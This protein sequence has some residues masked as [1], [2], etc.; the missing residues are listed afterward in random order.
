MTARILLS[1]LVLAASLAACAGTPRSSPTYGQELDQLTD[2]CAERGGIL[3]P[4][5]GAQTG[6]PQ[7]D[8]A[9]EIRGATRLTPRN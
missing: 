4:I 8:Y 1:S 5:S 2:D 3:S 7:T 6:R 9:C